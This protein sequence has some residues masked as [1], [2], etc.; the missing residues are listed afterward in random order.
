MP[1]KLEKR[2]C[3]ACKEEKL[4]RADCKTC[5]CQQA[6]KSDLKESSVIQGNN[7]E[8]TLPKTTIHTLDELLEFCKVDLEIWEVERFVCNKWEMGFKDKNDNASSQ[9]LYQVKA[10]LKRKVNLVAA[11]NEIE[12]LKALAK[13]WA[14]EPIQIEHRVDETGNLLVI[15]LSDHHFGKLAWGYETG[16]P[17]YDAKIATDLFNRAFDTILQRASSFVFDEIWFVVG[18][19]LLNSDDVY[20]RTTK[21][22]VVSTDIRYTKTMSIVRNT[23]INCVEQLRHFCKLVKVKMVSGN[24]DQFSVW[25]LGSSLECFFHNYTDVQIDNSPRYQKYDEF[26][27][28]MIMW[29][30]GDKGKRK[31]FPLLMATEQPKMFGRTK[32]R[33]V[34]TGH[35][36]TDRVEEQ[37]GVKVRTLSSLSP[38][39]KWHAENGYLGN[40]RSSEAFVYNKELGLV[41]T[42]VYTDNDEQIDSGSPTPLPP[43]GKN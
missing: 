2:F 26:G 31:D 32:F 30:H 41:A 33:E 18:N 11:K 40:L 23:L 34:H 12:E 1:R 37:H 22:T 15:N 21:G 27:K 39:D 25:H 4:M 36:H 42:I 9:P 13:N 10:F 3:P 17:N 7:W 38:A 16:H 43:R 6:A 19:D 29:T 14:P 5:G 35:L 28:I 8:V 20:G 24:H